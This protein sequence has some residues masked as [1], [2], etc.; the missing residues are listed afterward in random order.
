MV[1]DRKFYFERNG[2]VYVLESENSTIAVSRDFDTV[3]KI[4]IAIIKTILGG[5]KNGDKTE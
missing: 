3:A 4:L 1:N 2:E 5:V